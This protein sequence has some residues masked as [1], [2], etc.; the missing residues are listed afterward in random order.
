MEAYRCAGIW[1]WL[2]VT[3][4]A[5]HIGD[6]KAVAMLEEENLLLRELR[7]ARFIRL[8]PHLPAHYKRYGF[9]I[10]E[11]MEMNPPE[12][13]KQ[14][15]GLLKFNPFDQNLAKGELKEAVERLFAL[16]DCMHA[17]IPEYAV[18]RKNPFISVDNFVALLSDHRK[19][20]G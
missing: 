1:Y 19:C 8:L 11:A 13:A 14:E 12:G 15:G 20:D 18:V 6:P 5:R 3:P 9:R 17:I 7:G 4:P 10:D 2:M 16:F